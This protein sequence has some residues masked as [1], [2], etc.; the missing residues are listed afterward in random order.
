MVQKCP[1]YHQFMILYEVDACSQVHAVNDRGNV[2]TSIYNE[3][4]GDGG[5]GGHEPVAPSFPTI[6]E[7]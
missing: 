7:R 3:Q 6:L 4:H 2:I 1:T 5:G